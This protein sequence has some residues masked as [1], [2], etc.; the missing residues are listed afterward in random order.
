MRTIYYSHTMQP[1]KFVRRIVS[2]ATARLA[3]F[4]TRVWRKEPFNYSPEEWRQM[5]VSF[6]D[7]AEDLVV[8]DLLKRIPGSERGIYVDAGAFDPILMSNTLLLHKHG[9][10]GVNIDANPGTI[11]HFNRLR[12]E[13]RNICSA[14]SDVEETF[15]YLEYA[16]GTGNRIAAAES[17]ETSLCGDKP[18][19]KS[20][21]CTR[22]LNQILREQYPAGCA[23]DF[24]SIDCEGHDFRVLQGLDLGRFRPR[25]ICFESTWIASGEGGMSHYLADKGYT[26]HA[27]LPSNSIYIDNQRPF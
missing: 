18:L 24:L 16:G 8:W 4:I 12:P 5:R 19:R 7:S 21:I 6:A 23:I 26:C 27:Q 9:W 15:F 10:H 13:D 2:L 20:L 14:L 17:D 1:L 22:T 11:E 25:I 3:S